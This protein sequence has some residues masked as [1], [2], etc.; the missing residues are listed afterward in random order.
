MEMRCSYSRSSPRSRR[1]RRPCGRRAVTR[2]V[3][4]RTTRRPPI[5][6][7]RKGSPPPTATA[8]PRR[9]TS[10]TRCSRTARSRSSTRRASRRCRRRT[11]AEG[12]D[13][14]G[15]PTLSEALDLQAIAAIR[16]ISGRRGARP[17]RRSSLDVAG[18]SPDFAARPVVSHSELTLADREGRVN[19][20]QALDTTVSFQLS[21]GGL[22]ATGPGREAPDHVRARRRRLAAVG[23][24]AQGRACGRR[25]DHR[26]RKPRSPAARRSTRRTSSRARRRSATTCRS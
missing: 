9:S 13:E 18:L 3:P 12:K 23:H 15:N 24:A 6:S 14:Q 5:A 25:R 17:R 4:R 8:S 10:A 26:P 11:V 19:L 7:S 20:K 21:L 16:P 1:G 22:P 2:P